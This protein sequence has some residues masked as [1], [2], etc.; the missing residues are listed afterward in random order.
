MGLTIKQKMLRTSQK[1]EEKIRVPFA[2]LMKPPEVK[3]LSK[4][5]N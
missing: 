3:K 5:K 1:A 2:A 4:K